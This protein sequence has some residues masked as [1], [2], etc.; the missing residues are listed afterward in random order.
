MIGDLW[1][2]WSHE[3]RAAVA[4]AAARVMQRLHVAHLAI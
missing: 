4:V 1:K 2:Q 3:W